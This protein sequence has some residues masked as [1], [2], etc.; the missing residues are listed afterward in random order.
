MAVSS[1]FLEA[2]GCAA[3]ADWFTRALPCLTTYV[4][5]PAEFGQ[6]CVSLAIDIENVRDPAMYGEDLVFRSR[7]YGRSSENI[8]YW[9]VNEDI[10]R[11]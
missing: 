4:D 5:W 11:P 3:L 1:S 6:H 10:M 8:D 2:A 9:M 7:I